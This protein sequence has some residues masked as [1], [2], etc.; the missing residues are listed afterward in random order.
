MAKCSEPNPSCGAMPVVQKKKEEGF[1]MNDNEKFCLQWNDFKENVTTTFAQLRGDTD[2]ADVT[3]ACEDGQLLNAHSIILISGSPF[4]KNV[5][6]KKSHPHPMIYMRG[7]KFEQLSALADFVYLGEANVLQEDIESFLKVASDLKLK[8]FSEAQEYHGLKLDRHT[9]QPKQ[10]KEEQRLEIIKS[11][12]KKLKKTEVNNDK[13]SEEP[14]IH[15]KVTAEIEKLDEQIDSMLVA[16]GKTDPKLGK[17]FTCKLCGKE[18][19]RVQLV[20]HMESKHISGAHHTCD[21]C[22]TTSRYSKK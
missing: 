18:S 3:L 13:P 22:G 17:L 9:A 2:F 10:A 11:S 4:F 12:T 20:Q 15:P 14:P 5:L 16:T 7:I 19:N 1:T 8:G 21:V 6:G